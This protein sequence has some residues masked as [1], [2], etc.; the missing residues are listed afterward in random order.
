[1]IIIISGGS[2]SGKSTL[3]QNLIHELGADQVSYI[4][5]DSYYKDRSNISI[6]ERTG[7]NYDHPDSLETQLL[8]NHVQNLSNAMKIEKPIYNFETHTRESNIEMIL[9][10]KII[11]L[12]G[13]LLLSIEK[14]RE[15]ADLKIFV[16]TDA[17]ICLS[18]RILRDSKER[19]R[20]FESVIKQYVD[21]VKPMY[22]QFV[23]PSIKYADYVVK[24]GGYN[25]I[26]IAEIKE[27][28]FERLRNE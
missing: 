22:D 17:D 27:L 23:K 4:L 28:I 2:G 24:G 9:P 10:K 6:K 11:L 16:D 15:L 20:N 21:T 18:R 14:I 26:A 25:K 19:G 5:Q 13:I 1:M 12:D 3:A 8:I 7:L